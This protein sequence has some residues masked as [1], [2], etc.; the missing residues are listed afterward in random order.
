MG[1]SVTSGRYVEVQCAPYAYDHGADAERENP[2]SGPLVRFSNPQMWKIA[3]SGNI[4][5]EVL[6]LWV[7][8]INKSSKREC[9]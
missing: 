7:S 4:C 2:N 5:C 6:H 3:W 1:G 9:A 8:E